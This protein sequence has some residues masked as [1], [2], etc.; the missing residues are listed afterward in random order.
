MTDNQQLYT[1]DNDQVFRILQALHASV[2]N[3]TVELNRLGNCAPEY[4]RGR[5]TEL[6][7]L[8]AYFEDKA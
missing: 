6:T 2:L 8:I 4:K 5:I 7:A 3:Y 1:L